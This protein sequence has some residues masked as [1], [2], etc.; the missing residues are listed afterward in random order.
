MKKHLISLFAAVTVMAAMFS[1][2]KSED[3]ATPLQ[4]NPAK[5][6]ATIIGSLSYLPTTVF[7]APATSA[8][9][10]AVSSANFAMTVT[11]S[12]AGTGEISLTSSQ[13]S[14]DASTGI[15][16]I[17]IPTPVSGST[18]VMLNY[19][20]F[21]GSQI[22]PAVAPATGTVTL[23]GA[24]SAPSQSISVTTGQVATALATQYVF[25]PTAL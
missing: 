3:P 12:V 8:P 18:N 25:A 1:C 22:R 6:S 2:G 9:A 21:T 4:V 17:T 24:F 14:Y 19:N 5:N 13:I 16:K 7:A 11:Y 15:Y 10:V 23:N 20:G